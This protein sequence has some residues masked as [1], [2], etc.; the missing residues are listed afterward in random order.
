V[1]FQP[2]FV[3]AGGRSRLGERKNVFPRLETGNLHCECWLNPIGEPAVE[4]DNRDT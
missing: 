4:N 3:I 1:K 2:R